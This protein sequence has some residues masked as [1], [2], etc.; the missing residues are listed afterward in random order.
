MVRKTAV[1]NPTAPDMGAFF[2]WGVK[3]GDLK[4]WFIVTGRPAWAADGKVMHPNDGVAQT[5]WILDDVG[6]YLKEAGYGPSD[7]VRIE[8]TF[9]KD[10]KPDQYEQIFGLFAQW[11]KDAPVKPAA[12]TLRV[13][14]GLALDGLVVEY[15]FWAAK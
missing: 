5:R 12:S 2:S 1:N 15:E 3:I 10:V 13:V 7:L 6:R 4:E 11:L 9:T 8:Y 14:E